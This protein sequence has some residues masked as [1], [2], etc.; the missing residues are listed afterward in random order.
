[1]YNPPGRQD[2]EAVL[3]PLWTECWCYN[4]S[5]G[6]HWQQALRHSGRHDKEALFVPL[7]TEYWHCNST[8][9]ELQQLVGHP[10]YKLAEKENST[11]PVSALRSSLQLAINE[12]R[13]RYSDGPILLPTIWERI[14]TCLVRLRDFLGRWAIPLLFPSLCHWPNEVESVHRHLSRARPLPLRV[15]PTRHLR[16]PFRLLLLISSP[17]HTT[18][19]CSIAPNLLLNSLCLYFELLCSSL[20]S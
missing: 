1:M 20:I 10:Q 14:Q 7:S 19:L 13:S 3:A 9:T 12:G 2:G 17:L 4:H 16:T 15:T 11:V 5:W 6:E 18:Y 8:S